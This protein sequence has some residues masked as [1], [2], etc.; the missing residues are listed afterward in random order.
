MQ[1]LVEAL[2]DVVDWMNSTSSSSKLSNLVSWLDCWDGGLRRI[3]LRAARGAFPRRAAVAGILPVEDQNCG[4]RKSKWW[5][6]EGGLDA[7]SAHCGQER[8]VVGLGDKCGKWGQRKKSNAAASWWGDQWQKGTAS[9]EDQMSPLCDVASLGRFMTSGGVIGSEK[10][11]KWSSTGAPIICHRISRLECQRHDNR[12]SLN[13]HFW[14]AAVRRP[15][16]V[17]WT[18][19]QQVSFFILWLL[20]WSLRANQRLS[21]QIFGGT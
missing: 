15:V 20:E 18:H 6:F 11:V 13:R 5:W 16:T 21:K 9:D 10:P 8:M 17:A 1:H 4:R 3:P 7:W 2:L 14:L 12:R 19:R